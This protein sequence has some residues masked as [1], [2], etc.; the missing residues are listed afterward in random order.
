MKLLL[1]LS[2]DFFQ[3]STCGV[4]DNPELP[5]FCLYITATA[6]ELKSK[7]RLMRLKQSEAEQ[8]LPLKI[9]LQDC[10]LQQQQSLNTCDTFSG[11]VTLWS[12]S[13]SDYQCLLVSLIIKTSWKV[14]TWKIY[15]NCNLVPEL[16]NVPLIRIKVY[17]TSI[18]PGWNFH[19]IY[20]NY[21]ELVVLC[22]LSA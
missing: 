15:F 11:Q 4:V 19:K 20:L 9:G 18:L 16:S 8:T 3:C 6:N 21:V 14:K 7:Q 17:H 13:G 10:R 1:S 5:L 2:V 22:T 12:G